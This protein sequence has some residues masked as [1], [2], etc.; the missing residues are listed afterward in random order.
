MEQLEAQLESI[1]RV[2]GDRYVVV[3]SV[4][5]RPPEGT[6]RPDERLYR[7]EVDVEGSSMTPKDDLQECFDVYHKFE[8]DD[9]LNPRLRRQ[10]KTAS[11]VDGVVDLLFKSRLLIP[12]SIPPALDDSFDA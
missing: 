3:V 5:T 10:W 2:A 8:Y 1:Q 7:M 11:L 9:G 4:S 6:G 12:W